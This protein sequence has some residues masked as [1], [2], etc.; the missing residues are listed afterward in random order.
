MLSHPGAIR[1]KDLQTLLLVCIL[2]LLAYRFIR[3]WWHLPERRLTIASDFMLASN[4]LYGQLQLVRDREKKRTGFF[5]LVRYYAA[6]GYCG[7]TVEL[8]EG[9]S[10]F[11][12]RIIGRCRD[13]PSEHVYS[14]DPVTRRGL[15]LR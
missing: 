13:S 3:P 11:P 14:F 6:C 4:Q 5:S 8:S 7:G 9:G 12:S 1:A 2:G 15:P 10:E